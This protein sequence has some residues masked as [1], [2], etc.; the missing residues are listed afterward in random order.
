MSIQVTKSPSLGPLLTAASR[1]HDL[2]HPFKDLRQALRSSDLEAA[3]SAYAALASEAPK[4]LAR[5]PDGLVAQI[6]TALAAGD[7]EAAR[8][9]FATMLTSHLPQAGDWTPPAPPQEDPAPSSPVS[10]TT[11]PVDLTV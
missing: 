5:R 4:V 10:L 8:S 11:G 2:R 6:G 7:V 1:L 9:A 3:S